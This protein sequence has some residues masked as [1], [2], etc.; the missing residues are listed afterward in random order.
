MKNY[1]NLVT[2]SHTIFA[3]PFAMLGFF[4]AIIDPLYEFSWKILFLVIVCMVT[5]RNAAMGFN[6][7]ADRTI[8]AIND[9]TNTREIPSGKITSTQAL[10]FVGINVLLFITATWFI[11]FLCFV[12]SPVALLVILG[13]SYTKRFTALCHLVLGLGLSFA[14][15]GAYIAVA[16]KI[17]VL[18]V[19]YGFVVLFW[20]AGFD[21]IYALQD[22]YFDRNSSLRSIPERLGGKQAL[23]ISRAFHVVTA[24]TLIYGAFYLQR[25]YPHTSFLHFAGLVVFLASLIYQHSIVAHNDLSKINKAFFT[26]NGLASLVFGLFVIIDLLW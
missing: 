10:L 15:I 11:N 1:F 22:E 5:A 17:D 24:V 4:L 25:Y 14:P 12:L 21:I 8:D 20:V 9:R 23:I 18:P 26:T 13:Y 7:Y 3:M 2:F 16:G 6:R 19:I